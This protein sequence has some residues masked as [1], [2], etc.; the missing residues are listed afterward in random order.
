MASLQ[1]TSR[2][3][4]IGIDTERGCISSFFSSSSIINQAIRSFS[5]E[6]VLFCYT[7]SIFCENQFELDSL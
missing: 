7:N 3:I 4:E 6:D 2:K 5:F 1:F